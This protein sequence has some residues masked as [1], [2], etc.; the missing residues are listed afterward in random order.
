MPVIQCD[1]REG[2]TDEQKPRSRKELLILYPKWGTWPSRRSTSLSVKDAVCI[3][4][5]GANRLPSTSPR[6][7]TDR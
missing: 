4:C 3:T 5:L 7:T 6:E 2:W 1:I